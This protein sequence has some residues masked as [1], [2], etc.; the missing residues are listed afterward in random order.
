MHEVAAEAY[1]VDTSMSHLGVGKSLLKLPLFWDSAEV[2]L[3]Y[4]T[5]IRKLE[6]GVNA[7]LN[8]GLDLHLERTL[9]DVD[10]T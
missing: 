6:L 7:L 10:W 5:A 2:S 3:M 4:L 1:K 9:E 8:D